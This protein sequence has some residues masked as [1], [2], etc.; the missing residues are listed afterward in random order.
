MKKCCFFHNVSKGIFFQG[1]LKSGLCSK[2]L[3]FYLLKNEK[4]ELS[5]TLSL[6]TL[7]YTIV[8]TNLSSIHLKNNQAIKNLKQ[9]NNQKLYDRQK[10]R[11]EN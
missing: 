5:V 9:T 7:I 4:I 6:K 10:E 8:G 2:M 11:K 1:H 3:K